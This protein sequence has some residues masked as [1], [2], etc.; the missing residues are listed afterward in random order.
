MSEDDAID[1]IA[2]TLDDFYDDVIDLSDD[3]TY[4]ITYGDE[5][6]TITNSEPLA[7]LDFGAGDFVDIDLTL[8][9]SV[10]SANVVINV[11]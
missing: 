7:D 8:S 4:N 6:I 2:I 5:V 10:L 3:K 1:T 11:D 9:E